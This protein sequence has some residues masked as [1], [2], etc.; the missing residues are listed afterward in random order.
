MHRPK[1]DVGK[2]SLRRPDG[3]RK[4]IYASDNIAFGRF[5]AGGAAGRGVHRRRV[6]I[7]R[8]RATEIHAAEVMLSPTM[9]DWILVVVFGFPVL[10]VA[11]GTWLAIKA[12]NRS[13]RRDLSPA[14]LA[15]VDPA[16]QARLAEELRNDPSGQLAKAIDQ[17]PG[18][19]ELVAEL[20]DQPHD[21]QHA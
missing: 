1:T 9:T 17:N 7:P 13:V 6:M 14:N 8:R 19:R 2:S 15:K 3:P 21:Q 16:L 12:A 18:G 20:L 10:F 4:S 11:G 5:C